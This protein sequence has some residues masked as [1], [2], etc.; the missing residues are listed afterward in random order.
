MRT[1]SATDTR[2][3]FSQIFG[4]IFL[5]CFSN[6]LF[7]LAQVSFGPQPSN[8]TVYINKGKSFQPPLA[9]P[10]SA[11]QEFHTKPPR[12]WQTQ[13]FPVHLLQP[14]HCCSGDLST[15]NLQPSPASNSHPKIQ[16]QIFGISKQY[17]I[18]WDISSPKHWRTGAIP[19]AVTPLTAPSH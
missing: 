5:P 15:L 1:S 7:F 13:S 9:Y 16:I 10:E 2:L 4:W 11:V 3:H 18:S 12:Q 19:A 14:A 8:F 17:S 6:H